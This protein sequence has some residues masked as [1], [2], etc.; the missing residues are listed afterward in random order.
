MQVQP[1]NFNSLEGEWLALLPQSSFQAVFATPQWQRIWWQ[2]FGQGKE[3]L[4]LGVR[5]G[6]Q[7]V[8]V[9]P[10]MQQEGTISFIGG[11]DVCDYLDF[12]V[13]AGEEERALSAVWRHLA[14]RPWETLALHSLPHQSQT[15]RILRELAREEGFYVEV[16]QEEVCPQ[17]ALPSSW[18]EYLASLSKKDRHELQRKMRRLHRE[19][20]VQFYAVPNDRLG[21]EDVE[22]FLRLHRE[23]REDKAVFMTDD[24]ARFFRLM[25]AKLAKMGVL[26]LYFL[27]VDGKRVSSVLCF[28]D[29]GE[30]QLY[31]SGFDLAYSSLSVG[32]LIKAFCIQAAIQEGKKRFNFL[33]GNELYKYRLGGKDTPIYRCYISRNG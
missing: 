14:S 9:A 20:Q 5:E 10:M 27:D 25:A 6:D 3:L 19:A 30:L 17:L 31:N 26:R 23:S 2:S 1:T 18:E 16:E 13:V 32:L 8:A 11:K 24:M 4:L 7:L 21:D 33:R 22:D 28:N 29:N 15:P 12:I